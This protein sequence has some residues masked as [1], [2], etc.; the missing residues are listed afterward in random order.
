MKIEKR[1]LIYLIIICCI[2]FILVFIIYFSKINKYKMSEPEIAQY[3]Q[4]I[5]E[6]KKIIS[7]ID[8][9]GFD[10]AKQY[11]ESTDKNNFLY[12]HISNLQNEYMKLIEIEFP[13]KYTDLYK[14]LIYAKCVLD[15]SNDLAYATIDPILDKSVGEYFPPN[16]IGRYINKLEKQ[17]EN[18]YYMPSD[19]SESDFEQI[20]YKIQKEYLE[21]NKSV[22]EIYG[23]LHEIFYNDEFIKDLK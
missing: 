20:L 13:N 15:I 2:S 5:T 11:D 1:L 23:E 17:L 9:L 16:D 14:Q 6:Y 3:Q 8:N 21:G 4:C 7:N 22:S 18:P 10:F 12:V 19:I